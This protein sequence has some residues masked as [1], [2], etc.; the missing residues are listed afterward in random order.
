MRYFLICIALG[1]FLQCSIKSP[2]F[3]ITGQRTALEQ[4]VLGDYKQLM[5]NAVSTTSVR[6]GSDGAQPDS[7]QRQAILQS[8]QN[9]RFNK[10][11]IDELKREKVV[12]ENNR[13][14]LEVRPTTKY[15]ENQDYSVM[16]DKLVNEENRDRRII[17]QRVLL[18]SH[19]SENEQDVYAI[20]ANMQIDQSPPGTWIQLANNEWIEKK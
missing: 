8:V 20:F 12:G 7:P 9:Q 2:E 5:A 10:D 13:G 15:D 11:E 17:Y 1:L 14:Y 16:V 19:A 4:Q 3:T 6:M 18:M